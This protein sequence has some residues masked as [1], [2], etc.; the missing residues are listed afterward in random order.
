MISKRK[1][2]HHLWFFVFTGIIAI[3]FAGQIVFAAEPI[4]IG[5]ITKL[6]GADANSGEAQILGL[7][8]AADEINKAG[9]INGR[10]IELVMRDD[11][12]LPSKGIMLIRELANKQNV[13]ALIGGIY[14]G[15]AIASNPIISEIKIPYLITLPAGKK[16]IDYSN[17]PNYMFRVS[18]NDAS[19]ARFF[20]DF[21]FNEVK[22]TNVAFLYENTGYGQGGLE[23]FTEA[24]QESGK[25]P[26]V[27]ERFNWGDIDMTPQLMKAREAKA[28]ALVVYDS[29]KEAA[30]ILKSM[31]KLGWRIPMMCSWGAAQRSMPSIAGSLSDGLMVMQTFSFV[32]ND[33]PTAKRVAAEYMKRKPE[34]KDVS[35]INAPSFLANAYEGMKILALAIQKA[36]TDRN[37]LR[38]VL[39]SELGPYNGLIRSFPKPIFTQDRHDALGPDA[40]L[41]TV[42][43]KGKLYPYDYWKKNLKGK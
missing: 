15:N 5:V 11:E 21:A 23:D 19:V 38:D 13:V 30:Q 37:K 33:S 39:E 32:E 40:Y 27:T 1:N 24:L 20:R 25:K 29:T 26:A 7:T 41:M 2:V 3:A 6:S 10:P 43:Y 8:I 31:E 17:K 14:S 9:G 36:G 4:R 16:V 35:E 28:D 34:V 42:W 22:A 12:N 18:A